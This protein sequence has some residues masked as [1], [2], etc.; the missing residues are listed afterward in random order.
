M[1]TF[2]K[3]EVEVLDT[4][5]DPYDLLDFLA[6]LASY[7]LENDVELHDGETIGFTADDKRAITR[8]PGVGLPEEQMTLK[9]SWEPGC[10]DLDGSSENDP[11]GERPVR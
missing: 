8:S 6:S 2:G 5:A 11:D 3:D 4:D 10:G 1:E 7:V 9:I